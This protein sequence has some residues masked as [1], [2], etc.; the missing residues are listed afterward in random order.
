[1]EFNLNG[2]PNEIHVSGF[3][4]E[5]G[6]SVKLNAVSQVDT[7]SAT[8]DLSECPTFFPTP[9]AFLYLLARL[10]TWSLL[11]LPI[12]SDFPCS[13]L[14]LFLYSCSRWSLTHGF[15]YPEDGGNTFLQNVNSHKIY[16][17]PHPRIQHCS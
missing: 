13:P 10:P 3:S 15:F 12:S 8:P 6:C 16:T 4:G 2:L 17:V 7:C 11:T 9:T 5:D 14:S 1:M